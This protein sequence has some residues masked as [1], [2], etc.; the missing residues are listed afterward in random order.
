MCRHPVSRY[1]AIVRIGAR[2]DLSRRRLSMAVTQLVQEG[3]LRR[4]ID[5][6]T[7]PRGRVRDLCASLDGVRY[8]YHQIE[9]DSI[10]P[11]PL[12]RELAVQGHKMVV[13]VACP[14]KDHLQYAEQ[15][16]GFRC[17]TAVEKPLTCD[18]TAAQAL[19]QRNCQRL[20]P[21]G[22]QLF[23]REMLKAMATIRCAELL[24]ARGIEFSFFETG[25]IGERA[26]DSAIWDTC[27]HGFEVIL[28][29][30]RAS[31]LDAQFLIYQ[32]LT[33][34]YSPLDHEALPAD[35]TAARID[36]YVDSLQGPI[37]FVIR[38][39]KG[40][41]VDLKELAIWDE[42]GHVRQ[43]ISLKETGWDPHYRVLNELICAEA[44]NMKLSLGDTI[45]IV[46]ACS[47]ADA[48]AED[49]GPYPIGYTPGFLMG[50][51]V[52]MLCDR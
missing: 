21:V 3:K 23:K 12:A 25:S 10:L 20:Y 22:H 8:E 17:R 35:H 4:I 49:Q 29:L 24:R 32:V 16:R 15:L 1:D 7:R 33:G 38:A 19:T 50:G 42:R 41:G 28:A 2:G 14:T 11:E 18:P 34:T 52:S 5:V 13:Y 45:Q 31:G 6:D 30:F 9:E 44:P 40:L 46:Q 48:K 47:E 36:G 27:W 43:V 39:G 51:R 26:I 37:P